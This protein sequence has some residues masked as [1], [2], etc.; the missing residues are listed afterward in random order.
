M[1]PTLRPSLD[2][3][4]LAHT[5]AA[6]NITFM[7]LNRIIKSSVWSL[8]LCTL[9]LLAGCQTSSTQSSG[10]HFPSTNPPPLIGGSI[11][12][13]VSDSSFSILR[14]GDLIAINFS[15]IEKP[16]LK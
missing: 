11:T 4:S 15:D 2:R 5:A 1:I 3:M 13:A 16:P 6:T 8:L 9:V 14:V 10:Q 7:T 12:N